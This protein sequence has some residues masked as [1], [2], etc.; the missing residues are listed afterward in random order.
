[1][2]AFV[3]P[4]ILLFLLAGMLLMAVG[5]LIAFSTIPG[6]I[7][8]APIENALIAFF[9]SPPGQAAR[10]IVGVGLFILGHI[11]S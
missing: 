2:L 10:A 4:P 11:I 8:I 6:F 1:M 5:S 9:G 3:L 7:V